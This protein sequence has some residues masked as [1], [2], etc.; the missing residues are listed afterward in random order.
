MPTLKI[1]PATRHDGRHEYTLR[2]LTHLRRRRDHQ[3]TISISSPA[4]THRQAHAALG[5]PASKQ[6]R[7]GF[8]TTGPH[9]NGT[10]I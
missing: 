2:A 10:A 5:A 8:A 4:M 6:L 3:L 9:D 7:A 1:G